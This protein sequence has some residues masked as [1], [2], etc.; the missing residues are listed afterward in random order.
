MSTPFICVCVC[1]SAPFCRRRC[2][3]AGAALL[4]ALFCCR[5]CSVAGAVR[6]PA[7]F[8]C[9]RCSVAGA[10]LLRPIVVVCCRVLLPWLCVAC[11]LSDG[12]VTYIVLITY[13]C[14]AVYGRTALSA[15]V[16]SRSTPGLSE[17]LELV[18]LLAY[19]GSASHLLG[20]FR[21]ILLPSASYGSNR[22]AVAWLQVTYLVLITYLCVQ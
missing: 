1:V 17:S 22:V 10:I 20:M 18:L 8:C 2:S 15:F 9:R 14:T 4:P 12:Q 16:W 7:L 5:R 3:V 11:V 13:L 21:S 19:A 6:L